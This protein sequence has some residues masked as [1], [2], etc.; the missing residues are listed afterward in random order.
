MAALS[1]S[2][3]ETETGTEVVSLS[4][5]ISSTTSVRGWVVSLRPNLIFRK[6]EIE[7]CP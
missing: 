1:N 4:L 3:N 6:S 7:V 5:A 2:M